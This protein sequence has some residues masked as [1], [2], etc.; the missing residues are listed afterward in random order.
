MQVS[1]QGRPL[2][3]AAGHFTAGRLDDVLV[4]AK[5]CLEQVELDFQL[6]NGIL[7]G[8]D[9]RV[10]RHVGFEDGDRLEMPLMLDAVAGLRQAE[11]SPLGGNA[12]GD[13][14]RLKEH[15][16]MPIGEPGVDSA[17]RT[18][19]GCGEIY[20][21]L[22]GAVLAEVIGNDDACPAQYVVA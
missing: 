18:A 17:D 11:I 7:G 6:Q 5:D 9:L 13:L 12:R 10:E 3:I 20:A 15:V 22:L 1:I 16:G 14:S 19:G 8:L 2:G 4:A 21:E